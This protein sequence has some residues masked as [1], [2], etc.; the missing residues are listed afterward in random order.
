MSVKAIAPG[1]T[2]LL[3]EHFVVYGT[4]A[5][6]CAIQKYTSVSIEPRDTGL[7]VTSM[8][9]S[10][11]FPS[12]DANEI[13]LHHK[14]ILDLVK[15][16]RKAMNVN[17]DSDIP[18][19]IGLGSSSAYCVAAAGAILDKNNIDIKD[20]AYA[21]ERCI[22][23]NASGADT[24]VCFSGG[25]I[26][27]S[28]SGCKSFDRNDIMLVIASTGREH[29]TAATVDAVKR[30][31]E[32]NPTKFERARQQVVGLID[33]A[34]TSLRIGDLVSLGAHMS[35][36]HKC[37]QDIGVSDESMDKIV[38]AASR[39]SYGAKLTGA[40]A[41]GCAIA[42]VD[43]SNVSKTLYSMQSVSSDAFVVKVDPVGLR[44]S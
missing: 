10:E 2:I 34:C 7:S 18:P 20:A 37:L 24:A 1:K 16:S 33:D 13:S 22:F 43:N 31:K 44:T 8:Y 41:G 39:T 14:P 26:E 4:N 3:G 5:I 36:N 23:P 21:A 27:F 6:L 30:N 9:G 25:I 40:G 28:A 38:N 32:R 29:S 17:I 12:I 35:E 15:K 19:G 42:L 11:E